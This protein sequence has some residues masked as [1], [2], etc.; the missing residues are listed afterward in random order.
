MHKVKE[1]DYLLIRNFF[2]RTLDDN[3][4]ALF[5]KKIKDKESNFAHQVELY[6]Y[7]KTKITSLYSPLED[8]EEV[9]FRQELD[10]LKKT[11]NTSF[12]SKFIWT[13]SSIAASI[14]LLLSIGF[15]YYNVPPSF[16]MQTLADSR[17]LD[18]NIDGLHNSKRSS[19]QT[20][21]LH[22]KIITEFNAGKYEAVITLSQKIASKE[23]TTLQ[24]IKGI[25]HRKLQQNEKAI[26]IFTE[27]ESQQSQ[28]D[29]ILWNFVA[30]YLTQEPIDKNSARYYLNKI[31]D[32]GYNSKEDAEKILDRLLITN[33]N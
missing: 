9:A 31:R 33:S 4:L 17:A 2:E 3:K 14:A 21:D 13:I 18:V 5:N 15:Q 19:S 26:S 27:L 10:S 28:R 23:T 20:L 7:A 29:I 22:K 12:K 24:L 30:I 11:E 25:S 8:S 1:Q 16:N 32:D 6:E